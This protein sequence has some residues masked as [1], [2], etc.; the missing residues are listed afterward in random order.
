[1]DI[2]PKQK[3]KAAFWASMVLTSLHLSVQRKLLSKRKAA[4]AELENGLKLYSDVTRNWIA[5]AIK[6]VLLNV[7]VY[8]TLTYTAGKR[9]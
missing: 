1:M 6:Q 8:F 3:L 9:S 7:S 4:V 5:K 2:T